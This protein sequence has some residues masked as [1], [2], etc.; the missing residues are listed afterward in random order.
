MKHAIRLSIWRKQKE[1]PGVE[2]APGVSL[3]Q[4]KESGRSGRDDRELRFGVRPGHPRKA[5]TSISQAKSLPH[6]L[7]HVRLLSNAAVVAGELDGIAALQDAVEDAVPR[8]VAGIVESGRVEIGRDDHR[9]TGLVTTVDDG[10]DMFHHV[11]RVSL[12]TQVLDEQQVVGEDAVEVLLSFLER[13][14][15]EVHD[16]SDIRLEGGESEV[17]DAIRYR[18]GHERLSCAHIPK[19]QESIWVTGIERRGVS[20]AYG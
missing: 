3:P 5:I 6:R 19:Q 15:H 2:K 14:L 7:S 4:R 13:G 1:T 8:L 9:L 12:R 17:D 18:G 20:F 10:V 16:V 11:A